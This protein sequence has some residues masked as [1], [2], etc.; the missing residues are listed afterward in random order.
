MWTE[1]GVSLPASRVISSWLVL[2]GAL[3]AGCGRAPESAPTADSKAP[4]VF[5][6]DLPDSSMLAERDTLAIAAI[7]DEAVIRVS[8]TA[9]GDSLGEDVTLPY[10]IPVDL[11]GTARDTLR[12]VASAWDAAGNCGESSPLTVFVPP[13]AL[14]VTTPAPDAAVAGTVGVRVVTWHPELVAETW[15]EVDGT[16]ATA[17]G[18]PPVTL[19][20][21]TDPWSD[22]GA[23]L[24]QARGRAIDDNPLTSV[25]QTVRVAPGPAAIPSVLAPVED[26]V[27]TG[28]PVQFAWSSLATAADYIFELDRRPDFLSPIYHRTTTETALTLQVDTTG[29]HYARVRARVTPDWLSEWSPTRRYWQ[30]AARSGEDDG[31]R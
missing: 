6:I 2:T 1:T 20:W 16:V 17:S 15:I 28:S 22:G 10:T 30:G 8:A 27:V 14:R 25:A 12:L 24:L 29:W 4:L 23:H 9:D 26:A 31:H 18:A 3:L 19:S 11:A 21:N 7:D 13:T 5:F